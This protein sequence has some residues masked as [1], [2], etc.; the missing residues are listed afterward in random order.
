MIF[1][2]RWQHILNLMLYFSTKTSTKVTNPNLQFPTNYNYCN[3]TL[4][5]V[6]TFHSLHTLTTLPS[7][8]MTFPRATRL[9]LMLAPSRNL[10]VV[11]QRFEAL[12]LP[13]RSTRVSLIPSN[14]TMKTEWL[15]LDWG[16]V[17]VAPTLLV[18]LPAASSPKRLA[19]S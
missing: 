2:S 11:Q 10:E 3:H 8:E 14:S 5:T 9:L 19:E 6:I 7:A 13:A 18:L 1:L 12:S 17:R 15:L 16:L 4:I